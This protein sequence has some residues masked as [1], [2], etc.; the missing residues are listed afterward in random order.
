[1]E[2]PVM[3]SFFPQVANCEAATSL[4]PLGRVRRTPLLLFSNN[5]AKM[6][7]SFFLKVGKKITN[8][9]I[10]IITQSLYTRKIWPSIARVNPEMRS[11][12][13]KLELRVVL[14]TFILLVQTFLGVCDDSPVLTLEIF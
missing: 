2:T 1:M 8:M 6:A 4:M 14:L 13:V 3:E 11:S 10:F 5:L 9:G 7:K 12:V